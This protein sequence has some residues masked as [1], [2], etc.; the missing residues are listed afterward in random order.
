MTVTGP[1]AAA[2]DCD[3]TTETS[4]ALSGSIITKTENEQSCIDNSIIIYPNPTSGVIYIK[5]EDG[6]ASIYNASGGKILEN[7]LSSGKTKIDISECPDGMYLITVEC[8]SGV[9]NQKI[10]KK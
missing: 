3:V 6:V 2:G 9:F 5:S 10:I 4:S 8:S 7:K 1:S